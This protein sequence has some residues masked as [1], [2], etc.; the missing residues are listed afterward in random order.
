MITDARV[1]RPE[2]VPGEVVHREQAV[3]HLAATLEPI[4]R[5][6]HAE[7]ALLTGPS[8]TG[9]TCIARFTV[10]RLREAVLDVESEYVNCWQQHTRFGVLYRILDGQGRATD[11]HRQSTPHD[12]LLV[13]LEELERPLVVILDE[14][15]QLEDKRLLYD[16]HSLPHVALVLIA[17]REA[18]V[19]GDVDERLQS[20]L[21]GCER[22]AF[23]RYGIGELVAIMRDRAEWGLVP[24]AIDD[25]QLERIADAAAGDARVALSVLRAAA[26]RADQAGTET[27]TET[28]VSEA[29]PE[30]RTDVRRKNVETLTPHQRTLLAIVE[31]YGEIHPAELYDAYR[32]RVEE[33][34]TNRTVRN[35]LAKMDQYGLID[36]IG[37]GRGRTYRVVEGVGE[38]VASE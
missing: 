31:D 37:E 9:K 29:I 1:L 24:G 32:E 11:V 5:G 8:G 10:E 28:H 16:L 21:R 13:R 2:F 22:V 20:R 27:I 26:R 36:A 19:F 38:A 6:N 14:V 15:D 30:G 25:G 33:P 4:Q 35:Y 23:D 12:E 7:P 3:E 17:N 34:K 18:A